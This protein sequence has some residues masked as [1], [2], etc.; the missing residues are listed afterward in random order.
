MKKRK[1]LDQ[2]AEK[3]IGTAIEDYRS[4]GP[5]FLESVYDEVCLAFE[6]S[7]KI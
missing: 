5:K 6:L 3:I 2:I 4:L 1:I 7:K